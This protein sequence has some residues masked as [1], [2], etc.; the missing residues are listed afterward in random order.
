M[1]AINFSIKKK[2]TFMKLEVCTSR[3]YFSCRRLGV[4]GPKLLQD[5]YYLESGLRRKTRSY[6]ETT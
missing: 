1:Y 3:S 6:K 5:K 4:K 2:T